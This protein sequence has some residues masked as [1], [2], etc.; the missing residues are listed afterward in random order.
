MSLQKSLELAERNFRRDT[1]RFLRE[2]WTCNF[3]DVVVAM[4]VYRDFFWKKEE[5]DRNQ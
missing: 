3:A 1:E 5:E 4:L 2:P